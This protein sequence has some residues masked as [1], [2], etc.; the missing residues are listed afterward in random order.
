LEQ[1]KGKEQNGNAK[2]GQSREKEEAA[3]PEAVQG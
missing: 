3:G 1:N 2:N